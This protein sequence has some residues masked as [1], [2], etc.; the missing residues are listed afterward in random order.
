MAFGTAPSY[1]PRSGFDSL[2]LM[3]GLYLPENHPDVVNETGEIIDEMVW[4][5]TQYAARNNKSEPFEPRGYIT[6]YHTDEAIKVIEKIRTG[7]F[8]IP[9]HFAPHNPLQV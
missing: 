1:G 8:F 7:P 5:S 2:Q 3:G 6:D 9:I 4:A